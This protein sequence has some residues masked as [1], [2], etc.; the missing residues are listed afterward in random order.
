MNGGFEPLGES[1]LESTFFRSRPDSLSYCSTPTKNRGP[2][3]RPVFGVNLVLGGLFHLIDRRL[4][5]RP[6]RTVSPRL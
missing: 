6:S 1:C 4:P 3:R 2:D 5:R